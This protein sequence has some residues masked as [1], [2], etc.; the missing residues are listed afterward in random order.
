MNI[1]LHSR[2]LGI[3]AERFFGLARKIASAQNGQPVPRF[4][5]WAE[6]EAEWA[7]N[8]SA[9]NGQAGQYE[10]AARLLLDLAMLKW[11]VRVEGSEIELEAPAL[12]S[13]R[14]MTV[15]ETKAAKDAVRRELAPM[16]Y[17]Q[18]ND[19]RVRHFLDL[20]ETPGE[21]SALAS[22]RQLIADGAEVFERMRPA[23]LITGDDRGRVLSH[24]VRPYLQLVPDENEDPISDEFTGHSL[25]NIWRYFRYSW[26]IPNTPIPGRRLNYLV[27]DAAHPCHAVM[28]I[29]A[30]GNSPMQ[31]GP[32]DDAIG[33]STDAF[34]S[35]LRQAGSRRDRRELR[36]CHRFL[37]N[38]LEN[39]LAEI[40]TKSLVK[41]NELERP[42]EVVI[43]RLRRRSAEF[44]ER[45]Q[46]VLQAISGE[47]TN[48]PKYLQEMETCDAD[49]PPVKVA[50]LELEGRAIN[51][52]NKL[53]SRQMLVAKKRAFELSRLLQARLTLQREA[54]RLTD[55]AAI[56]G[57]LRE[58][59]FNSALN[60]TLVSAKSARAGTNML[61]VTTC[62]AIPPYNHLLAGKLTAL[63]LL[64]PQ[65][66]DDYRRRY[67]DQ[68]SV[69]SSQLKNA[70]RTKGC[71]L[72]WLNTTSLF[73]IGSSQ[74]ERLRLPAGI[75]ASEQPE[76]RYKFL[77]E[78]EGYGTVQFSKATTEAIQQAL[79]DET[80][81]RHV[82]HVFGEG[83]SPKFRKLRSGMDL[84]GF[85][86]TV[87]M[88]HDQPRRVYAVSFWSKAAEF[89]RGE[90]AHVPEFLR[91]PERYRDATDR[92]VEYW[93]R[94]WLA[95]RIDFAPAL[96]SLRQGRGWLLSDRLQPTG[97]PTHRK[98]RPGSAGKPVQSHPEL[99]FWRDL[100]VAGSRVCA[101]ELTDEELSRLHVPQPLDKFLVDKVKKGFSLILTG[102]AGDGK[103]HLLKRLKSEFDRVKAEVVYDATAIMKPGD[104]S[105]ILKLWKKAIKAG[106]PFCLAANEY[107]LFLL[108]R[109]QGRELP[110][111][112]AEIDRQCK[113]RLVYG[114]DE[115]PEEAA[116]EKVLVVDLSLRNPL[117]SG[118]AEK[119][120]QQMLSRREVLAAAKSDAEGDLAWNLRRLNQPEIQT[121]LLNLFHRLASAGRRATV[122]ELWILVARLLFGECRPDNVPVRSPSRWYSERLFQTDPRFTLPGL[123]ADLADPAR[124]SHPRWDARLEY[125]QTNDAD[126]LVDGV[127]VSQARDGDRFR[128]LKR[129]FY[130]EHREGLRAFELAGTPGQRLL[131]LLVE[132]R[133]P[134][135]GFKNNLVA[136]INRAY[137]AVP[138]PEAATNLYLWIGHRFHEQ[139]SHAYVA[140][141]QIPAS[142]LR[143]MLPRLP[144]R[145]SGAFGYQPDHV[146]VEFQQSAGQSVRLDVDYTLFVALEKLEQGLP[147]HLLPARD[148]NRL[149][150]F[151]DE[152]RRT[153][154]SQTNVFFIHNHDTRTTAK[155][156]LSADGKRYEEVTTFE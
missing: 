20:M 122:R 153:D 57:L 17:E 148:V 65:V 82:N 43:E 46:D 54:D 36:H 63:L 128:A 85:N 93:R 106:R 86:A 52:E 136:A 100:A 95:N 135:H 113:G 101:D 47:T 97:E 4:S 24:C 59:A 69:I 50:L 31:S 30:L 149:D 7:R 112:I 14:S 78:T 92:I 62:G 133:E 23:L 111:H 116:R 123:L 141:Q 114:P 126:W 108:R 103:T 64:S 134:D 132:L 35:R 147:R 139:P 138:F 71:T 6:I 28:G 10:A 87:L 156:I 8:N 117:V 80:T 16:L 2:L 105:P 94:R 29:A 42:T 151:L 102:N 99:D 25:G 67:G 81:Y 118:F 84:L 109:H 26:S 53:R 127:P 120:L 115:S 142:T 107:P 72:A 40:E 150:A 146:R 119:L 125:S 96:E 129:R 41:K 3:A 39:A 124:H 56:E 11:R 48:S 88:R 140:C 58:D 37:E 32:R 144:R 110:Q 145:L 137:C 18:F 131:T 104:V 9:L 33:W 79:E 13:R 130:F 15:E 66:A 155:I 21:N 1:P 74:Y 5:D 45:R 38:T 70:P 77:G 34:R 12:G 89:L 55:P 91:H 75:I 19:P 76:I 22:I 61:E 143:F 73:A 27:R 60:T 51:D 98:Q 121:R 49:L 152:L 154:V 68:P 90:S 83:P 44:A